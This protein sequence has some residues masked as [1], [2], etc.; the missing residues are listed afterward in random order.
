MPPAWLTVTK[1]RTPRVAARVAC[2]WTA[3]ATARSAA[4]PRAVRLVYA[5]DPKWNWAI[6]VRSAA[7][8][9]SS[10]RPIMKSCPIRCASVIEARVRSLQ[11]SSGVGDGVT[12]AG[13]GVAG[14]DVADGVAVGDGVGVGDVVGVADGELVADGDGVDRSGATMGGAA[15]AQP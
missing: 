12:G 14:S 6:A 8:S 5:T 9:W 2:A 1:K 4:A 13:V 10:T 3:S 11:L 7:S 15:S